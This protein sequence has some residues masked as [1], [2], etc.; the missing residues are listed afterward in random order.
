MTARIGII[1]TTETGPL[2]GN[3]NR[4]GNRKYRTIEILEIAIHPILV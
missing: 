3:V 2:K 4:S 1:K